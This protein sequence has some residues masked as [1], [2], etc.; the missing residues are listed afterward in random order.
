MIEAVW[1]PD[2]QAQTATG[3]TIT[4]VIV[5]WDYER[6]R[7]TA[8]TPDEKDVAVTLVG[9][10]LTIQDTLDL[11][12]IEDEIIA[13]MR[14]CIEAMD[15]DRAK[16][17]DKYDAAQHLFGSHV[18]AWSEAFGNLY[19][20]MLEIYRAK[21]PQQAGHFKTKHVEI[22]YTPFETKCW[23][24]DKV[25][26]KVPTAYALLE[27]FDARIRVYRKVEVQQ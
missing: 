23:V 12:P 19:N 14:A 11:T 9:R 22:G 26:P 27:R 10:I 20:S 6:D 25:Q 18:S 21:T 3:K 15:T 2:R 4:I 8:W 5:T 16:V 7:G 17:R 13:S 24:P 1:L